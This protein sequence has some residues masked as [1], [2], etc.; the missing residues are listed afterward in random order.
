MEGEALPG[1]PPKYCALRL[2]TAAPPIGDKSPHHNE[3]YIT[4]CLPRLKPLFSVV[5]RP[6]AGLDSWVPPNRQ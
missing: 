1:T 4:K 5:V 6:K 3:V 2:T